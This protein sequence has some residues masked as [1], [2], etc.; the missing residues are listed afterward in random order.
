MGAVHGALLHGVAVRAHVAARGDAAPGEGAAVTV[1][2]DA[3]LRFEKFSGLPILCRNAATLQ[4]VA[5]MRSGNE[6]E[7]GRYCTK[8]SGR[9]QFSGATRIEYRPIDD[10]K[11]P[12]SICRG[13]HGPDIQH[14][15]E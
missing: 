6:I 15:C 14:A 5:V 8:H 4:V 9:M 7:H 11:R 12:C 13:T 1:T 2:C 10:G 3:V